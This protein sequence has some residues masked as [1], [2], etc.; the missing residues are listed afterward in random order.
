MVFR[1]IN[2]ASNATLDERTHA[3]V[4]LASKFAGKR[5]DKTAVSGKPDTQKAIARR[6]KR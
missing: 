1:H 6:R 4:M 2:R 5:K 3:G